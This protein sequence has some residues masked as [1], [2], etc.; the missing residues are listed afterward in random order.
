MQLFSSACFTFFPHF[1]SIHRVT[2]TFQVWLSLNT[3]GLLHASL[4]C[5]INIYMKELLF[6]CKFQLLKAQS[7]WTLSICKKGLKQGCC[8]CWLLLYSAILCFQA[9]SLHSHV[10]LH[11]WLAFHRTFLNIHWSGV[12]TA[13][14]WLV[15]HETAA[16]LAHSVYTI[17]PCTMSLHASHTCKV[18]AYLAVTCQ[19]HF[20][21]NDLG[22]LC[23]TAATGWL[24][25]YSVLLT[26]IPT[27]FMTSLI[28]I[29]TLMGTKWQ[30]SV[31]GFRN[32]Q[33][34]W[35]IK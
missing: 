31:S 33:T 4:G 30:H 23:A 16:I 12:L 28:V 20:R 34:G 29:Q 21:Q 8:Y 32:F 15:P 5:P 19:L 14:A 25:I 9:D 1:T 6:C 35:K 3:K 2:D 18:H 27:L 24:V 26:H 13:L 7:C 10:I 11:E 22:L 17:Q